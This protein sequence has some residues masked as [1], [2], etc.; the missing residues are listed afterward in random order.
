MGF[1][2][3][4][5]FGGGLTYTGSNKYMVGADVEYQQWSNARFFA[6]GEDSWDTADAV[7][8][9][10]IRIAVGG[11]YTP[12]AT[13]RNYFGKVRYRIG[14]HYSNSYFQI[15]DSNSN[16]ALT[17]SKEYGVSAG[18]GLPLIDNRSVINLS[19]DYTAVVPERPG[20]IDERYFK[21]TVSYTMN[22]IWF[23]KIRLE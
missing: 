5:T 15:P 6:G 12:N 3:P 2:Y 20:F 11:Q 8:R 21:I 10:K 17:G 14:G 7:L 9:D 18:F 22:E 4:Q 19:F 1:D 23:R 16:G 13:G